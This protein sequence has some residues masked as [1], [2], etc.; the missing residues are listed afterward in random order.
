MH[1][2]ERLR[3]LARLDP[4]RVDLIA[5]EAAETLL[6]CTSDPAELVVACRRLLERHPAAGPLWWVAS[7]ALTAADPQI[8]LLDAARE[9]E[10]DPTPLLLAAELAARPAA[11]GVAAWSFGPDGA[12]ATAGEV[13]VAE[14]AHMA[15]SP[16][17]LGAGVGRGLPAPVWQ[18]AV[19]RVDGL[20]GYWPRLLDWE[21]VSAVVGA[22]GL[23]EV[24]EAIAGA[25]CPIAPEILR[26]SRP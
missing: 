5:I 13:A 21:V 1:P 15:G 16:V 2:I 26:S 11:F 6:A 19:S 9:L 4:S 22:A 23:T 20:V 10:H 12:F 17:L 3:Y 18:A 25:S 8:V 24:S 14:E 7:S